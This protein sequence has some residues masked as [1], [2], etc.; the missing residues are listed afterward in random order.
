M[1]AVITVP[2]GNMIDPDS[3]PK[4][5]AYN[6]DGTL[7]YVQVVSGNFTYRQTLS[8]SSGSVSGISQWTKQ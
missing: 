7:N 2:D 1:S 5:L 3:L 4:T 6:G 8:Y